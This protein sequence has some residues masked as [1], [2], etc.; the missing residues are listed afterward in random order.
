MT[1]AAA[2]DVLAIGA[3]PVGITG[4]VATVGTTIVATLTGAS[5]LAAYQAAI[6]AVMY[7]NTSDNPSVTARVIEVTVNDGIFDSDPAIHTVNVVPMNDAPNAVTDNVVTNI[8]GPILIPEWMMLRNDTD[9]DGDLLDVTNATENDAGFTISFNGDD[10]IATR[11]DADNTKDFTY[12]VSDGQALITADVDIAWDTVGTVSGTNGADIILGDAANSTFDG[13]GGNDLIIAGAG[14]DTILGG[15][16]N[17]EIHWNAGDGRDGVNGEAGTDTI[18]INGDVTPETFSVY[19]RAAAIAAGMTGIALNTEIV[20][21]RN[22]SNNASIVAE[23][24]NIE[25]IVINT[26][27]VSANDG[28][29]VPNGGSNDG[30]TVQIFGN[31]V[32]TSL[33]FSTITITGSAA[34]DTVDISSLQ[35]AHRIVFKSN[36]GNDIIVGNLRPQDVVELPSGQ[37]LSTYSLQNAGNGLMTY[38]N[39][40]HSISFTGAVPPQFQNSAGNDGNIPLD[41]EDLEDLRDMVRDG[42]V[43][44]SSGY[45]NNVDNPTWGTA[46]NQFIRL[47]DAHFTDGVSGI[48]ETDLTPREISDILSNQDNDGD[49]AGREH[50]QRVRRNEP[51][52]VLRSVFRPRFRFRGEGAAWQRAYRLGRVPDQ[53]AAVEHR[54]RHRHR[55]RRGAKQ[56]GRD[57]G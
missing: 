24:D 8:A 25:E 47:T 3:L 39:G 55:S 48:R 29:G 23:L 31:F 32:G 4:N 33:N 7:R 26:L 17:D 18:V 21:T 53:C 13:S 43:R 28:N 9:A 50:T 12:T 57:T 56:R 11:S 34:D 37:D 36:G 52:H 14:N 20:I 44:D 27:N 10:V 38:T 45:G 40:S 41:D 19:T 15:G 1:N 35:S 16:G 51:A 6:Q 5:T 2:G 49:G 42:L 54:T 22:G 46:G 30:D